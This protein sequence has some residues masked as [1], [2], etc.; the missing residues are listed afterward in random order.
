[1]HRLRN[2]S[3]LLLLAVL[4]S[5]SAS[6]AH[7]SLKESMAKRLVTVKSLSGGGHMGPCL[8]LE[9]RNNTNR[10]LSLAV[11]P[12]LIFR[13]ADTLFQPLVTV[14]EEQITLAAGKTQTV[15]LQ[16]FC[17]KSRARGP[18]NGLRYTYWKQGDMVMQQVS[19]YIHDHKLFGTLGQHAMWVLTSGHALSNVYSPFHKPEE[20]RALVTYMAGLL[21]QKVPEFYTY[22]KINT[23]G[24]GVQL[25]DCNLSKVYV[26]L[27]WNR[28]SRR[29]MHVV[30]FDQDRKLYREIT[31]GQVSNSKGAHEI[32]V[33]FDPDRDPSGVY[34]VQLR[35]D[36][37]TVWIEKR[38]EMQKDICQ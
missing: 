20:G 16:A 7:L 26:H 37:S 3:W 10:S 14:G 33:E 6:A 34:Y 8:T 1:M 24:N 9:L 19:H 15:Y 36:E 21:H 2:S 29:Q 27:N 13:P 31:S 22:H 23:R 25:F 17:G 32:K 5:S 12:A 18:V 35:D 30:I 11:D 28:E 38:V 4:L